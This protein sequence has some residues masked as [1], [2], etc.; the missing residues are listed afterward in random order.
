MTKNQREGRSSRPS[1]SRASAVP[2][3]TKAAVTARASELIAG[4]LQPKYVQPA[5]DNP[6]WN[7]IV[8]LY[9]KWYQRYFYFC[10][11]YRVAPPDA[12]TPTFE[13]RFARLEYAGGQHFHLAFPQHTG[14]WVE[15]YR[16]L[17]LEECLTAIQDEPFFMP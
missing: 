4:V 11:T 10:A 13:A 1:A 17:P 3:T 9:G 5:P 7:S 6:Q 12:S 8:D 14:Q 15:L 16:D 2:E